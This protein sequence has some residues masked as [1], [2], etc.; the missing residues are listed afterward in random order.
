MKQLRKTI[1]CRVSGF[2]FRGK[3]QNRC[4]LFFPTPDT[5]HPKPDFPRAFTLAELIIGMLLLA[6][7]GGATAA[8][9]SA[10]SRG[11][12]IG[13]ATTSSTLT[14]TRTMLR[15]QD[16][17][18]RA[19]VLGQWYP[20]SV[21]DVA[22]SAQGAAVFF[23]RADTNNDGEMQLAETEVLEHNP[24]LDAL[25]VWGTTS[26]GSFPTTMLNEPNAIQNFKAM[27]GATSHIITNGVLGAAFNVVTPTAPTSR[28]QLEWR[29]RF[30]GPAGETVEYGTASQRAP[31]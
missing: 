7:I 25:V 22:D 3:R 10:I 14:I 12:Q 17:V 30:A 5:R 20:G 18:H 21:G 11:W 2:G 4:R 8:V 31:K 29:L 27:P 9:A 24:R 6:I 16:K 28:A 1:G 13:E 26:N 23:W 19:K 15:I